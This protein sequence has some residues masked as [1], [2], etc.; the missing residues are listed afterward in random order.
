MLQGPAPDK[1]VNVLDEV[2]EARDALCKIQE[3]P[4][5][6]KKIREYVE[7]L[8]TFAEFKVG[9]LVV[10]RP[11][12]KVSATS[13][14]WLPYRR[15]LE[16]PSRVATVTSIDYSKGEFLYSIRYETTTYLSRRYR[17]GRE[18]FEEH[19]KDEPSVFTLSEGFLM[20]PVSSMAQP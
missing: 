20:A 16:D 3:L 5:R 18:I 8:F 10:V 17:D 1:Y 14:G 6:M 2:E 12:F 13:N 4:W 11:G 19:E 9:D 7:A 15:M